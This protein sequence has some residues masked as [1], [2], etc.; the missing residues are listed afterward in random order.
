MYNKNDKRRL[1]WLIDQYLAGEINEI[2]FC[3]DFH[4]TFVNE[5]NYETLTDDEYT[6]FSDL[7]DASQRF[8][9]YEE[10]FK[11]WPGFITSEELRNK[12]IE[13]KEKLKAQSSL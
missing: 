9:E 12:I 7:S 8:S 3:D 4:N 13:V 11:L 5:M 6:V 10:D 2:V 1:Y